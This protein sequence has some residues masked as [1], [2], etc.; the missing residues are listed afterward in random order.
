MLYHLFNMFR[1][2]RLLMAQ[3]SLLPRHY[4]QTTA[5]YLKF[6]RRILTYGI[7]QLDNLHTQATFSKHLQALGPSYI[8]LG[9]SLS[10]RPDFIGTKLASDLQDLQDNLPPCDMGYINRTIEIELGV[11]KEDIFFEFSPAIASASIAQIHKAKL[12]DGTEI[13]VKILRP[14]IEKIL[15][16]ELASF[17]F[18]AKYAEKFIPKIRRLKPVAT[19]TILQQSIKRELDLR[20]EAAALSEMGDNTEKDT[21]IDIPKVIWEYTTRRIV[22][23]HWV[24]G[25]KASDIEMLKQTGHDMPQLATNLL[26]NFLTHT[27]RDGFF[28]ADM[29]QGNILI[30]DDGVIV[31]I[32]LGI[33]GRLNLQNRYFLAKIIYGFITRD[34]LTIAQ[35]HFDAGYIP[36]TTN[37]NDFSQALRAIGEPIHGQ[38][39]EQISMGRLLTQ[40]FEV[41][42]QFNMET[43]TQLLLLQKTMIVVEGV[44]RLFDPNINIWHTA[45]PVLKNWLKNEMKPE[46]LIKRHLKTVETTLRSLHKLPKILENIEH[47]QQL[48]N[49]IKNHQYKFLLLAIIISLLIFLIF[50]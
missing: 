44:C 39:A 20:M 47:H 15:Y 33:M 12:K 37:I 2:T 34:Y 22:T 40:L 24:N 35:I 41:T 11:S 23:M 14:N 13:A 21:Q 46:I 45:E 29:H 36:K 1:F 50:I 6:C 49:D 8:K 27:L 43:Q 17:L 25:K 5:F 9:Q 31:L 48:Q 16:D 18:I 7:P 3:N 28:H 42:A 38:N 19:V 30:E 10:V 4:H 26:Q 32:D